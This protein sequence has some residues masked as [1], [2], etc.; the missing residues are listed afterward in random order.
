MPSEES[1]LPRVKDKIE[2]GNCDSDGSGD[3]MGGPDTIE[4][5]HQFQQQHS[6]FPFFKPTIR[7]LRGLLSAECTNSNVDAVRRRPCL[8]SGWVVGSRPSQENN[9]FVREA[10]RTCHTHFRACQN[11]A[12]F[13][14]FRRKSSPA[15][16]KVTHTQ[17]H[18]LTHLGRHAGPNQLCLP[19]SLFCLFPPCISRWFLLST[20]WPARYQCINRVWVCFGPPYFHT[21]RTS[22][23]INPFMLPHY[24]E[25]E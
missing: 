22:T 19:P 7:E 14:I 16:S 3:V 25:I 18:K 4:R 17:A 5:A 20:F 2:Q 11:D 23:V 9:H 24:T 8:R 12:R 10:N 21:R 13:C 6:P 1:R 15:R